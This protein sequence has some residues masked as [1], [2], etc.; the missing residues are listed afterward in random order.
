MTPN[1]TA[2]TGVDSQNL[3]DV[4][5]SVQFILAIGE[6]NSITKKVVLNSKHFLSD[7][8]SSRGL[9]RFTD[10]FFEEFPQA[11][12]K[13][14]KGTGNM[15][16]SNAFDKLPE[17]F[18]EKPKETVNYYKFI[19]RIGGTRIYRYILKK[20][21]ISN[22]YVGAYKVMLPEANGSGAIGEVLSTPLIGAPLI[23]APLI[24]ATDTFISIG[25]FEN[26]L[27][28]ENSLKY[29]KT[30]FARATLGIKKVTQHNPKSTW[31]Y[32]PLQDF[33]PNS[34]IDWTKS[35]PEIDQQ[36]YKKY[37]LTEDE[38]NFIETKV[39]AMD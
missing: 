2:F 26:K 7:L 29:I 4:M 18:V 3:P 32:V 24:G 23:G 30:K 28:A 8:V 38:I 12:N 33:T 15:V 19:G 11:K 10:Q 1:L 16:V 36:L 27:E 22:E 9:Y 14:G 39:Q 5:V 6:L 37:N 31:E 17:V 25:P 20:Y 21:I 34:D 13:L 35:I